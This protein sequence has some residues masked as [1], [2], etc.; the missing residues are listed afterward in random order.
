[1]ARRIA[2]GGLVTAAV[3][4]SVGAIAAPAQADAFTPHHTT[5]I[6]AFVPNPTDHNGIRG[7]FDVHSAPIAVVSVGRRPRVD[8]EHSRPAAVLRDD[9]RDCPPYRGDGQSELSTVATIVYTVHQAGDDDQ[10]DCPPDRGRVHT[11]TGT[12]GHDTRVGDRRDRGDRHEHGRN[13]RGH[14]CRPGHGG[15]GPRGRR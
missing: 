11:Y 10:R 7:S 13:G 6:A 2:A 5:R 1:M 14:D 12:I 3:G 15:H 9:R 8:E 4:L